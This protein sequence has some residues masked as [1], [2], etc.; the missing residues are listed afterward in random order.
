[1]TVVMDLGLTRN[2]VAGDERAR[3]AARLKEY[4]DCSRLA[5][6]LAIERVQICASYMMQD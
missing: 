1:M 3:D 4:L 6:V 2:G 5:S